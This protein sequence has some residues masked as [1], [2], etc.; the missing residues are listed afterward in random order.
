VTGSEPAAGMHQD[1]LNV[2]GTL[3]D[4][5]GGR[6]GA[7][8]DDDR[9]KRMIVPDIRIVRAQRIV[10]GAVDKLILSQIS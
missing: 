9:A 4:E 6:H 8:A 5:V 10:E 2:R 3:A 7:L 1:G